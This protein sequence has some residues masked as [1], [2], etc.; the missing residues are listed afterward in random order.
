NGTD[1]LN[2]MAVARGDDQGRHQTRITW[3]WPHDDTV[4]EVLGAKK[5][6]RPQTIT[7]GANLHAS[8]FQGHRSLKHQSYRL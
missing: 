7:G 1:F 8:L 5:R 2:F 4:F 3:K 6:P